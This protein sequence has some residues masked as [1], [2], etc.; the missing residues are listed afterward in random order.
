[1]VC[2]TIFGIARVKVFIP[3]YQPLQVSKC[4]KCGKVIAEPKKI[5]YYPEDKWIEAI[6]SFLVFRFHSLND[7]YLFC[8][9]IMWHSNV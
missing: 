6:F 8:W 1:M 2:E 4:E 7:V 3:M 9:K 5:T